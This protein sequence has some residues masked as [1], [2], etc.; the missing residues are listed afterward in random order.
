MLKKQFFRNIRIHFLL[1][2][3]KPE[4]LLN[5]NCVQ[6]NIIWYTKGKWDPEKI[7][8]GIPKVCW[9]QRS[10]SHKHYLTKEYMQITKYSRHIWNLKNMNKNT[11]CNMENK[12]N[13][14]S[15]QCNHFL[16]E[17]IAISTF[18]EQDQLPNK[19]LGLISKCR[20]K[21]KF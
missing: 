19:G 2:K 11:K 8:I 15:K 5:Y 21:N 7:Y 3:T 12:K 4:Y 6:T 16:K 9:K 14:T 13:S 20:Y 1:C 18:A 17:E 10:Y